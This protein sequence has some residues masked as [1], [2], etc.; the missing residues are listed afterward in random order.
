MT[1]WVEYTEAA[2][3]LSEVRRREA[4]RATGVRQRVAGV[5]AAVDPV[6]HRLTL[7]RARLLRVAQE[8][9][10]PAPS[11][12]E[13]PRSGLTDI[14]EALRRAAEAIE[15]ADGTVQQA[16][17]RGRQATLL[18]GVH[19]VARNALIYAG[20]TAIASLI[21]CGLTL[22]GPGA[23]TN[24]L[25]LWLAPWALCGL[26]ALAFFAGYFIIANFGRPR[27]GGAEP[28]TRSV[29]LGGVICLL[30]LWLVYIFG[31]VVQAAH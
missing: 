10:L 3:R 14:D 28:T 30:G 4:E 6:K 24:R 7:Q 27:V 2:Q 22:F 19:P 20:T 25:P 29:R 18:P 21:T 11:S 16:E 13:I 31:I 1:W 23:Q 26:P 8:L 5:R 17:D 9:R 12:A 15:R